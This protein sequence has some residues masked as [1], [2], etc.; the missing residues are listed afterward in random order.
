MDRYNHPEG[1][2]DPNGPG[3][4]GNLFGLP[5]TIRKCK[6][7]YCSGSVGSNCFIYQL[8]QHWDRM[9]F[10]RHPHKLICF[11]GKSRISGNLASPCFQYQ[12]NFTKKIK[13]YDCLRKVIFNHL[14]SVKSLNQTILLP[15]KSMRLVK[16]SISI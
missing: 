10:L 12:M 15:I 8:A 6:G 13:I 9:R 3:I 16:I 5:F 11:I 7:S 1:Y 2:F 4:K 14:I